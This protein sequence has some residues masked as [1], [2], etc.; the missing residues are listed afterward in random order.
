MK[1]KQVEYLVTGGAGFIG[2]NIVDALVSAGHGVRVLD[3]F[4]TGRRANLEAVR[5]RIDLVEGDLRDDR[6]LRR[7]LRGVRYVIH[8]AAIPSVARSVKDP[9]A[10]N[11]V[12]VCGTLK[13]LLRARDAGADRVVFS[14]SS[15]VYGET[16]VLPKREDMT[17]M[18]LS[19]YA[20]SKL[21]GEHY[22][23]MFHA[24]YGLK[25]FSLRYFNVFG[26]RQNPKSQYAAVIPLFIEALR[27]NRRPVIYGDGR[28]TR[29]FTYIDDVVA[30]NLRCCRAP[31]AAAGEVY[32][33]AR[34][35]RVSV[36]ELFAVLSRLMGKD[37]AP[38][39]LPPRPGDIRH[40]QAD[41]GRAA[42]M[43]RWKARVPF[44][45]GLRRTIRWFEEH[46]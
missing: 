17:P 19:P 13:L 22:G 27:R 16:P 33:I 1:R 14:S 24:L 30:A 34:G 44:R 23:R 46:G 8:T 29:D 26:P 4:S 18:P 7:A 25:T 28:Q 41:A 12:N 6:I 39:H 45:E 36:N 3:D 31:A 5:Q 40:S 37:I 21:A 20:L 43:L 35:D 2:S 10:T 42:R 15:S 11:S 38:V 32:N 9:L